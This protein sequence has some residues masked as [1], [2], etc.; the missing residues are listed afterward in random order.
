MTPSERPDRDL[1]AAHRLPYSVE[2]LRYALHLAPDLERA[3]F[4][5]TV[6]IEAVC[7][8]PVTSVVLHAQ[9]LGIEEVRVVAG[10]EDLGATV[11]VDDHEDRLAIELARRAP[12]GPLEIAIR[13]TG[14]LN[15]LLAGFYRST[16]ADDE[17]VV[18]TIATT[19]FEATDARRAFPCIDEPDR[20]A[21]FSIT[22]DVPEGL[23]AVSNGHVV[24]DEPLPG[25]GR[26]IRFADTMK[27]STYLVAFVVG[28]LVA[29]EPV[30]VEG[31]PVRVVHVPGRERLTDFALEAAAH[32]LR[33]FSEWFGIPYPGDKLDLV[34]I[35]DFAFGAMEN[36]GCVTFREAVLLIDPARAS[37]VELERVADVVSHEIAHMWFGDLVTMKWWTGIWL[38]EAFAT[39][40]ELLCVDAFRPAWKRWV[41][42][43]LERDV[44]MA[45]DALH[46]TR[47]VEYP[48]G[49]P[50]EAQ[51]MFDVLT[52]QKGAS[53]LRMLER[54]LGAERFREGIRRYLRTH[55]YGNTVTSDLW[56]A[57]EEAS[58][59]PVRQIMESWILQ[60]GF[61]VV[62]AERGD[63]GV[64][65]RQ[66]P[67]AY[68]PADGESA[69]G[70]GWHVPVMVGAPGGTE[71]ARILL[72]PDGSDV[73]AGGPSAG[74]FVV[75]AGGSGYYRVQYDTAG[76][77]AVAGAFDQLHVLEQHNLLSDTWALVVAGRSEL[78]DFLK[79]AEAARTSTDPG[80]WAQI[81]APLGFLDHA[82]ADAERA[83]LAAYVRAL[84]GPAFSAL[85]WEKR[86]GEDERTATLR[87]QLL[88]ALGTVGHDEEVRERCRAMH[89]AFVSSGSS[90]DADLAPA[91][92][93]VVA[94]AGGA[95]EFDAFLERHR[96]PATPQEEVRYLYALAGFDDP[97]LAARAYGIAIGEARTQ[98]GPFLVH[99][100]L[101]NRSNGPATWERLQ[102]Q[103]ELVLAKFPVAMVP[104]MIDAVKLLCRD[105][106]LAAA[107]RD[108][109][110]DH[111]LSTGQRTVEQIVE[112]LGVNVAFAGRL[113][114][115]LAGELAAGLDR[116]AAR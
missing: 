57:I 101:A 14:V 75:N 19:Q 33:F 112:R 23:D 82:C 56:D 30:D 50:E 64:T 110:A 72:G 24:S 38:N 62:L 115:T 18:H 86:P 5:G 65:L 73:D 16:F 28:P 83:Q 84:V 68:A 27:M 77:Q 61:P 104:R 105:E 42:F 90:L 31:V 107:V 59:E 34:A 63:G 4:S 10:T 36:L 71:A 15:D 74:A 20:K 91:V 45:T 93:G 52:Y 26:R 47:P 113:R 35:P 87:S 100:L 102:G 97:E 22:I 103:W 81:T 48:V 46:R 12:A 78:G 41:S 55:S 69:I 2:P 9:D 89:A 66:E 67:F 53:V 39:L 114:K 29:T 94:A 1:S 40:M 85:G 11:G 116:A 6:T 54:Y 44:A 21:V 7:H 96:H 111:P 37:R 95:A 32:A 80:V 17:G 76:L 79:L 99:S 88:A 43:G 49:S 108:F 8:E 51:G 3:V 98:N 70:S 25:G 109:L 106:R 58:G 13:F 92:V 60:G